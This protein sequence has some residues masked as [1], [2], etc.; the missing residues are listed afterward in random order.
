MEYSNIFVCLLGMGTVF[1]GLICIIIICTLMGAIS[2]AFFKDEPKKNDNTPV[3][4]NDTTDIPNR[5]EMIAAVSAAIAEELGKDVSAIRIL[6]V[7]KL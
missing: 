6:S 2:K 1:V 7:K 3:L 5:Q 4:S